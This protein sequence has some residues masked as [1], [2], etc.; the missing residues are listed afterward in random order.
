MT[1]EAVR[2]QAP[3]GEGAAG[4]SAQPTIRIEALSYAYPGR[5]A[6]DEIS[7][8]IGA[9]E[10]FGL[11]GPNGSG[12]STLL[13]VLAGLR[14]PSAG[15]AAIAGAD[16]ARQTASVRR[17]IGVAFQSPSLPPP[18]ASRGTLPT[19]P[20]ASIYLLR[21]TTSPTMLAPTIR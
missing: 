19:P 6:L 3:K 10:L 1:V 20:L 16:V 5:K 17:C 18:L 4:Q 12:K 13:R 7:L 8:D 15:R 21:V 2:R 9:G 14:A 11:L